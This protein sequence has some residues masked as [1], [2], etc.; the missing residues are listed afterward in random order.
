MNIRHTLPAAIAALSLS[1]A[2]QSGFAASGHLVT[3]D[4]VD[5]LH[6]G[7]SATEV[8]QSLGAPESVTSW[9]DGK[10]SMVYELQSHTDQQE[11]VYV[12][13]DKNNKVT[14]VQ[15]VQR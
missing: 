7:I 3:Q 8:T 13:L 4:Q 1:L 11:L 5:R 2:A 10:H 9:M 14:D 15:V 12:D 6:N